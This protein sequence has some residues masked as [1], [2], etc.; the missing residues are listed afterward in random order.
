VLQH[1]N[2]LATVLGQFQGRNLGYF[3]GVKHP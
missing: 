3:F 2:H 1:F